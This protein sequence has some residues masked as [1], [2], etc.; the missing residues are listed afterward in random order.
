M[1]LQMTMSQSQ[2]FS[3]KL[4]KDIRRGNERKREVGQ[5]TGRAP[6]GYLNYREPHSGRG[7]AT[8][9]KDP[10]RF[11]LIR[12]AF[13]LYLTGE[14]SV[15]VIN[16]ILNNEWGY[17][18][19]KRRKSGGEKLSRTALYSVFRNVRYAGLIPDPYDNEHLLKATYPAMI[20]MEEYDKVQILLGRKGL[21]RLVS[22]K[23]FALRGFIRCGDC[24][25]TVTAQSKRRALTNGSFNAHTYYHCTGKRAG[26]SQKSYIKEDELYAQL[27]E[28]LDN[29]ELVP[30]MYDWAMDTFRSMVEHEVQE[31]DKL[32]TAQNSAIT[33]TQ[34][35]LD[36]LLDMASRGL[37]DDEE[38]QAKKQALKAD[39]KQL[40]SEQA[41]T[42][43]RVKNWYEIATQTFEK[44]TYAGEKFKT[45]DI[46]NKKDTLLAI[47]QNPKLMDG[48]LLI[49]PNEW[50][51]PVAKNAKRIRAELEKRLERCLNRC[52]RPPKRP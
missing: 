42:A 20:T 15:Q 43:Y 29:Y 8:V 17:R 30:K 7:E 14:Y 28:L 5:L 41:D 10:D 52:K 22:R 6:E 40:H 37:L 25:C 2:Y 31:R 4:S 33:S 51:T 3:S 19:L 47:G 34:N 21:P 24:D 18:T 49:T 45:G 44:L 32:Q 9:I 23:Q 48:K 13:D 27:L 38:Y 12:K 35:Q 11:D 36:K 50:L 16:N 1:M 46:G 39:L 26:C